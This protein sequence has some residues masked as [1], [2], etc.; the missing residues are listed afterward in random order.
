M[1]GGK[2]MRWV[3]LMERIIVKICLLNIIKVT[4]FQFPICRSTIK[5]DFLPSLS[6]ASVSCPR[7]NFYNFK[8]LQVPNIQN[9]GFG[10]VSILFCSVLLWRLTSPGRL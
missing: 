8:S 6:S 3:E 4:V 7:N 1:T 5:S 9:I 2:P 10:L